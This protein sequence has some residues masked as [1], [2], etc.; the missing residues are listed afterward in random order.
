MEKPNVLQ[1]TLTYNRH[2]LLERNVASFIEQDYDGNHTLFIF[3]TGE[4]T[5]LPELDLPAN[6]QIIL[7]NNQL[8]YKTGKPY[9][10]VGDKYRDAYT[11]LE[12]YDI[13]VHLDDDDFA[14]PD[15]ISQGVRGMQKAY[16]ENKLSYKPKYSW[17]LYRDSIYK[18][19]NVCEGSIFIDFNFMKSVEFPSISVKY[20]DCWV[21]PLQAEKML[22]SPEG[23]S[24]WIYDWGD[25]LPAYKMSG[26]GVDDEL[27]YIASQTL[28]KDKG[29]GIIT[30]LPKNYLYKFY[31]EI[32]NVRS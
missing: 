26:R 28:S 30:P 22:V 32:E 17:F 2:K 9:K 20:H 23:K 8:D 10:S 12:S 11:H 25:Y 27:N 19:E 16:V 5:S 29:D 13:V 1:L 4:S 15:N 31:E 3:N 24:T 7:I 18:A 14:F 21:H 6:K